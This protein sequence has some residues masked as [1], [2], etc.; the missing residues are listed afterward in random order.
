VVENARPTDEKK[1]AEVVE[2][3]AP[4]FTVS[5]PAVLVRPAPRSDVK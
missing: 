4:V 5:T 1:D 2:N 3:A